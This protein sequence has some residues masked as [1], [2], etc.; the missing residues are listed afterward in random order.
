MPKLS[1][2]THAITALNGDERL[3]LLDVDNTDHNATGEVSYTTPADIKT[4]VLGTG[5]AVGTNN[6]G[7]VVTTNGTQTLTAKTLTAPTINGATITGTVTVGNGATLTTPIINTPTITACAITGTTTI[8]AGNTQTSPT[9]NTPTITAP[10]ITGAGTI[11]DGFTM[12]TPVITAIRPTAGKSI[13]VPSE[14]SDTFATL[15]ATQTLTNKTLTGNV[16]ATLR[17]AAGTNLLTL[18]AATDTLVGKA[19]T[20]TLTNKT[21][22]APAISAA[23]ITGA[24]TITGADIDKT[25]TLETSTG[26][27]VAVSTAFGA[28]ADLNTTAHCCTI[29]LANA[30]GTT[31]TVTAA[32]IFSATGIT[33]VSSGKGYI[34]ATSVVTTLYE[35]TAGT[36]LTPV[37]ID[38]TPA[39][40]ITYSGSTGAEQ[41]TQINLSSLTGSTLYDLAITFRFVAA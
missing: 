8:G 37:V 21:L 38:A 40:T 22:T 20:D 3:I 17:Q 24:T 10:I 14:T 1:A 5:V 33:D 19:T 25:T 41:L 15:A 12:T 23:V 6:A 32:E 27:K 16:A 11:A 29:R 30:A 28:K 36:T 9:I 34:L 2:I 35:N 13:T 26:T 39:I 7:D 4:K 18:P 31:D